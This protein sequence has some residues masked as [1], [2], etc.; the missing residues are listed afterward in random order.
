MARLEIQINT[1]EGLHARP[2]AEFVRLAASALGDIRLSRA[3]GKI[4]DAK[5]MLSVLALG[6]KKGE[7]AVIECLNPADA[8]LLSELASVVN[9]SLNH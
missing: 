9:P 6:L 7:K 4:V 5:S 3:E 2:A 8:S 1:D